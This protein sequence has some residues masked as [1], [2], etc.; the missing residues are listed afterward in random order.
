M[1]LNRLLK[2]SFFEAL[3]SRLFSNR[4]IRTSEQAAIEPLTNQML[5]IANRQ[6]F[7]CTYSSLS[8]SNRKKPTTNQKRQILTQNS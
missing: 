6:T 7:V 5:T 8:L 4:G 2:D 3:F 1:G